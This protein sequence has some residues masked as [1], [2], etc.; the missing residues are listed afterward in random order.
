MILP[1]AKL[2]LMKEQVF[3]PVS[4]KKPFLKVEKIFTPEKR[5]LPTASKFKE[6]FKR[7]IQERDR[8]NHETCNLK[9]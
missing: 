2:K 8:A 3:T 4:G 6:Y 9:V 5:I 1:V 7:A